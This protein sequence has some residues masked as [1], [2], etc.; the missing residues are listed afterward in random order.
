MTGLIIIKQS[1]HKLKQFAELSNEYIEEG[2]E[3]EKKDEAVVL[4]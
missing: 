2:A 1:F 4:K 3:E